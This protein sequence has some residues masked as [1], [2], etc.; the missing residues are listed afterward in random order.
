MPEPPE[1]TLAGALEVHFIARDDYG[2]DTAWAEIVTLGGIV[3]GKGLA[4]MPIT[5]AL[6]LPI[7]GRALEVADSVIRDLGEHPWAG[8]WVEMTLFADF[9]PGS[10]DHF[11]ARSSPHLKVGKDNDDIRVA[12]DE[13]KPFLAAGRRH[14]HIAVVGQAFDQLV[15][16]VRLVID[17]QYL[18]GHFRLPS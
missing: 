18:V 16:N 4:Q 13:V 11:E 2:I 10:P 1:A 9:G 5:F 6:P 7:A 12:A 15:A 8:A 14:A 3:P 17:D